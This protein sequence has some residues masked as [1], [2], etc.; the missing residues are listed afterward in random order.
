MKKKFFMVSALTVF[1]TAFSYAIPD[2]SPPDKELTIDQG[3]KQA[4]K[5]LN[6]SPEQE[7]KLRGIQSAG[8]RDIM[9]LRHEIQ[10]AVFDIQEEY[11]KPKSDE[12]KISSYLDKL[13]EAQ[14]KLMKIR[15]GQMLKMKAVLTS[16]QFSKLAEKLDRDK[17][18][19]KKG[20]FG[21]KP[22]D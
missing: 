22:R 10:L 13:A 9:N 17:K 7:Q 19:H 15:S 14:K 5:E 21:G 6:L 18:K 12:A 1:L 4:L 11:K 3:F 2:M 8:K 20:L 16:E